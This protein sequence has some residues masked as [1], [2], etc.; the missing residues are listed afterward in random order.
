MQ[1][2]SRLT[3]DIT[4]IHN[5][6]KKL[7]TAFDQ[8]MVMVKA[9]AYGTDPVLLYK[10][11]HLDKWKNIPFIG[12]SHVWE[13]ICLREAGITTPIFVISAPPY[14]AE[15]VVIHQLTAAVSTLEEVEALNA[16]G[17]KHAKM[18]PVHLH[19]NTGMNRFGTTFNEGKI[20]Y[21]AIQK[22]THLH[23]EGIMT[24][25]AAADLPS[26]D[27]FTLSQIEQFKAFLDSLPTLPRW[28]H[29]ANSGGAVRFPLPFCNL[30]RIGLGLM[31]YGVCLEGVEPALRLSTKL[32]SICE[33]EKGESVSYNRSYT[34]TQGKEKIGVIP[35]GYHDGFHRSLS[36]KGYVLIREKK[37]PMIGLVCM[38]F[39]MINLTHI[40]EAQVG[41]EVTLFGKD[42][43]PEKISQWGNT[44]VRE[45]LVSLP[46][47]VQ[48]H[49]I[50][51][52]HFM[53][54]IMHSIRN[55]HDTDPER[56][57]NS[58]FPFEKD[59]ASR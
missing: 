29:A 4:V 40:P 39:M 58:L 49:W 16:A 37:A 48:R 3:V 56:L 10:Y 31:G 46:D 15:T 54:S 57:P 7:V 32:A 26:F 12:V 17:K 14:E 21:D 27:A 6:L 42:L 35:V 43:S 13:G 53:H 55:E 18:L 8:V 11:L 1:S 52:A 19:L 5:N 33:R 25:F 50:H 24:H 30:V 20:L 44:D 23:L 51:P 41:D 22:A 9:N 47:R 36:G 45:L 2:S 59:Q 28:I 38:D 34:L